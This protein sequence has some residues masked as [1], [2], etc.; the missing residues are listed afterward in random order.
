MILDV[1]SLKGAFEKEQFVNPVHT[2]LVQSE[3]IEKYL[4]YKSC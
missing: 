3:Q 4:R 1:H 2:N